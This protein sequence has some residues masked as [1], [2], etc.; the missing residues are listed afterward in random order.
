MVGAF[1]QARMNSSRMP[2]KVLKK[3]QNKTLLSHM[4]DRVKK[5]DKID[6]IIIITSTDDQDDAIESFAKEENIKCFRGNNDD[7]LDRYYQAVLTFPCDTIVRLTADCPL[8]DP[9]I[10]DQVVTVFKNNQYDFV[11][12]TAPPHG[13]TYPDG[14]D[15]EV[16]SMANLKRAWQEAEKP[17]EREHVTFYFWKNPTLFNTFRIDLENDLSAYRFTVDY[18]EDFTLVSH[19]ITHFYPALPYMEDM[20]AFCEENPDICAINSHIERNRGWIRAFENDRIA[21]YG[22]E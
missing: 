22:G 11:A 12:N 13:A 4:L 19:I 21:G 15:V 3:V 17:S 8:I 6:T 14:M 7:V 9:T 2:G 16:F 18:P 10:I 5:A 1:I 20:I